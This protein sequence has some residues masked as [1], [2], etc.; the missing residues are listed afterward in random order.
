MKNDKGLSDFL[1][2]AH[3]HDKV[4]DVSEAFEEYPVEEEW[5]KG[6]I[7]NALREANEEYK[8][9]FYELNKEN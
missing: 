6:K 4:R 1:K 2:F 7:E 5:H 3:E 8:S 9:S